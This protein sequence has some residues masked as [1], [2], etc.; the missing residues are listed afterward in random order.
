MYEHTK[1]TGR[2]RPTGPSSLTHNH[3]GWGIGNQSGRL[4]GPSVMYKDI[5]LLYDVIFALVKNWSSSFFQ[6]DFRESAPTTPAEP[7]IPSSSSAPFHPTSEPDAMDTQKF[8]ELEVPSTTSSFS[9]SSN[10]ASKL[11]VMDKEQFT[12]LEEPSSKDSFYF[13]SHTTSE[14]DTM[15]N[16]QLTAHEV[17]ST[18]KSLFTTSNKIYEFDSTQRKKISE[19]EVPFSSNSPVNTLKTSKLD[20]MDTKQSKGILNKR[21]ELNLSFSTYISL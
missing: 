1:W 21:H 2:K 9:S 8:T 19:F 11:D 7:E 10:M 3:A 6:G 14:P 18:I 17:Q 16:Q 13:N 15:D 5:Y 12:E 4:H 20:G